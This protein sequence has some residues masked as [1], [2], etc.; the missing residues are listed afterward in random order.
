MRKG[1]TAPERT[2]A[3]Q[4]EHERRAALMALDIPAMRAWAA[5]HAVGLLGDDRMVLLSLHEA[6]VTDRTMPTRARGE[7]LAWLRAEHPE[8]VVVLK[9]LSPR[10]QYSKATT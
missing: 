7:S 6:R 4:K 10:R 5:Q 8:S 9:Q 1:C 3:Q 2:P